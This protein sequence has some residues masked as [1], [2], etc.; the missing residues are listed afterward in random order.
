[1]DDYTREF[2]Q[3]SEENIT[4]LNNALLELEQSP[5]DKDAMDQVFRMAH[6]LK[7]NCGTMGFDGASDLAHAVEDRLDDVRAGRLQVTPELMDEI[8]DAVD[9]LEGMIDEVRRHGEPRRD[10]TTTIEHLHSLAPADVL[11]PPADEEIDDALDAADRPVAGRNVFFA[12]LDVADDW[13]VN[14]ARRV[15]DALVDA[16]DLLGTVPDRAAIDAGAYDETIDA[17]FASAVTAEAIASALEPV[18]AVQDFVITDVTDRMRA[19][20]T[21]A[22]STAIDA[23]SRSP[24][25]PVSVSDSDPGVGSVPTSSG[26][27]VGS[28]PEAVEDMSVDELLAEFDDYDDLDAMVEHI[29]DVEGFGE[30]GDAGT[31]EGVEVELDVDAPDPLEDVSPDVSAESVESPPV[32]DSADGDESTEREDAI[33]ETESDVSE[34]VDDATAVFQELKDEV[35]PVGFDELQDEL[36]DLEFDQYDQEDEVG[37]DELLTE[38]ELQEEEFDP[39]GT[40][41]VEGDDSVTAAADSHP[42]PDEPTVD[43]PTL[44]EAAATSEADVEDVDPEAI[45]ESGT[46]PPSPESE[47]PPSGSDPATAETETETESRSHTADSIEE[48]SASE[49]GMDFE[50]SGDELAQD[51]ASGDEADP[52]APDRKTVDSDEAFADDLFGDSIEDRPA[53]ADDVAGREAEVPTGATGAEADADAQVDADAEAQVDADAEAQVDADADAQVDAD[54]EAQADADTEVDAETGTV[55]DQPIGGDPAIGQAGTEDGDALEPDPGPGMEPEPEPVESEPEPTSAEP[56]PEPDESE[57]EPTSAEPEPEPDES[58]P[59]PTS[60]EPEP[61]PDE[62]EP[63]PEPAPEESPAPSQPSTDDEF[64]PDVSF[65]T[66][67]VEFDAEPADLDGVNVAGSIPESSTTDDQNETPSISDADRSTF[68]EVDRDFG[69]VE[70]FEPDVDFGTDVDVS[71]SMDSSDAAEPADDTESGGTEWDAPAGADAPSDSA[72]LPTGSADPS[73]DERD[74]EASSTAPL[75]VDDFEETIDANLDGVDF[76]DVDTTVEFGPESGDDGSPA[77]SGSSSLESGDETE[78]ESGDDQL[79][80][81]EVQE[82]DVDGDIAATEAD[83]DVDA[84]DLTAEIQEADEAFADLDL[85]AHAEDPDIPEFGS[86]VGVGIEA[87]SKTGPVTGPGVD[88]DRELDSRVGADDGPGLPTE[89]APEPEELPDRDVDLDELLPT[90]PL[91]LDTGDSQDGDGSQSVR[92][93]IDQVDTL[94]TL[95][96][97]LVTTR[98]RLRR[99]VESGESL[100]TIDQE[101]DDLEDLVGELQDIVMDVR[102]VPLSAVANRLPRTVRDV[103]REQDKQVTFEMDGGDV[104]IDRSILDEIDD[105]LLHLVRNAVDHGI[106]PPEEREAAG[107]DPEGTVTLSAQRRRDRVLVEVRDDGRGL[108]PDR[109]REEAVDQGFLTS[110]E[111]ADFSDEDAYDLVFE[112]G[113]STIEEVT[114]VSGRGVGM[115]VVST[116][117]NQFDGTVEIESEPGEGTTVRMTLPVTVAISD[118]LFVRSGDEEFGIP[119]KAVQEIG[120]MGTVETVDGEERLVEDDESYPIVRL[121]EALETGGTDRNGD[122]M[123]VKLR[124]E[125]RKVAIHCDEVRGQQEVVVRPF[126]GVLGDI[127]GLSGATVLGEGDVVHILDVNSL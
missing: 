123:L 78:A 94:L 71:P 102:L 103:A 48:A 96:E 101:I 87:D 72:A 84:D 46:E 37:F 55:D 28:T 38:E 125:T 8:F 15:V 126:E 120:G 47:S 73:T 29:E 9:E 64:T 1:M 88:R 61:E 18:E 32:A 127:P 92:V 105:P 121:T 75:D 53:E 86:D 2:V 63:E 117:V 58:E 12:R 65:E 52:N 17:V 111:A 110:D 23:D 26:G 14:N 115:D 122:G 43:E 25:D 124:K 11:T 50:V 62:S 83:I 60:A 34:D 114:E 99:S 77:G 118:V 19:D 112:S 89:V 13:S 106:E 40:R 100:A 3:E 6:T 59:E 90:K 22:E 80:D 82:F 10:P 7:G 33:D 74:D 113:F 4:R 70:D 31:F 107:K 68:R 66:G 109:L 16:F 116:T 98:A 76:D 30:L 95:V 51:A 93:D 49:S 79:D 41:T 67:D 36:E 27:D 20:S 104:E 119:L 45:V 21:S 56:E 81:V 54:A 97:G 85:E 42:T 39:F 108:D 57:P 24:S 69:D 91:E 5:D 44:G 35:D